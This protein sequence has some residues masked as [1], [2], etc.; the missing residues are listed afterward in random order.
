MTDIDSRTPIE[1]YIHDLG[2]AVHA[3]DSALGRLLQWTPDGRVDVDVLRITAAADDDQWISWALS[4]KLFARWHSGRTV[5][6][7]GKVGEGLGHGLRSLG[8]PGARGPRDPGAVR[9]L[10]RLLAANSDAALA[11]VLDAAG[12]RLRSVDFPPHWATIT[13]EID[14][15]RNP[16]ARTAIQVRWA[17]QFHTYQPAA[18]DGS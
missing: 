4:G 6:R 15:W 12:R 3:Q 5:V 9:L 10:D 7:Y 18:T 13:A 11:V 1:R 17:R 8:I 16:P 2:A 14:E